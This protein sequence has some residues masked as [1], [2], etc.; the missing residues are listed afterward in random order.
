[1]KRSN[2]QP[3]PPTGPGARTGRRAGPGNARSSILDAARQL[4]AEVGYDRATIRAIAA[5]AEV[6]PALIYRFFTSKSELLRAT[7][8]LPVNPDDLFQVL[9]ENPGDEGRALV[10]R[11][12]LLW[13][14]PQVRE[15]FTALLRSAVSQE[16]ARLALRDLLTHELVHRLQAHA[17]DDTAPLRAGLVASQMA[18]L[19]MTKFVIGIEPIVSATDEQIIAAVGPTI[20]RYLTGPLT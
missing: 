14:Q 16:Q 9:A 5:R 2:G 10:A 4:F 8:S 1:M 6:D 15:Q 13:R 11:M 12:L 20:Q 19:G 3:R 18:G 7:Q 17:A